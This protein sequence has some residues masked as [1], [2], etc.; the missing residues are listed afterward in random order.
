MDLNS[1]WVGDFYY[2]CL[3]PRP[4]RFFY[5]SLARE[6]SLQDCFLLSFVAAVQNSS[7]RLC[8][9]EMISVVSLQED[10][11]VSLTGV[12]RFHGDSRKK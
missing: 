7:N 12:E 8:R 5:L 6:K 3:G 9:A 2:V 11:K 10:A 4:I 1:V